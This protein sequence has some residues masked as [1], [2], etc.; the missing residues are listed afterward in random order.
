MLSAEEIDA[1]RHAARR[2][3][4]AERIL[5]AVEE[6]ITHEGGFSNVTIAQILETSGLPRTTFYRYF[7][8]KT[9]LLLAVAEPAM[10]SI[11]EVAIRPWEM[12]AS[13]TREGLEREL[14][15]TVEVYL[16]HVALLNAMT[17]TAAYDERVREQFLAG[18]DGVRRVVAASIK[19]GQAEGYVRAD[20]HAE[21]TAGW[22]TWMAERGMTQLALPADEPTR[23][24]LIESLAGLVWNGVYELGRDK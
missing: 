22:I 24:R 2:R 14:R 5:P 17:E 9:D 16:P 7:T 23:T 13:L 21:E 4:I 18:F 12:A 8:D 6:L 15:K 3:E 1:R 20:L 10:R 19:D 11:V